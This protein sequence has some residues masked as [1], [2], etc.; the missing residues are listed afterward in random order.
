MVNSYSKFPRANAGAYRSQQAPKR[1]QPAAT[2]ASSKPA[3]KRRS[4]LA[5]EN[6][7]SAEEEAEIQETFA[8][9]ATADSSD[10]LTLPIND[11]RR[12]LI[13]LSCPPA[14][15]EEMMEI[16]ETL[17]ADATDRVSYEHFLAIAAIKMRTRNDDPAAREEEVAKAFRLFTKGQEREITLNDL[18]RVARELR[19][20]VPDSLLKDMIREAKGGGLG[21]VG[22]EEFEGVMRR[23]GVFG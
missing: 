15:S 18:R 8:L 12:A 21:G 6:D 11:V 17:N 22:T 23:A 13:A 19:E 16:L 10:E 9:F 20:E 4:K 5:K 2:A 1:K 14:N 7:I 3:A